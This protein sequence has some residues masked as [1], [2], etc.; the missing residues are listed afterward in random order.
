M[1]YMYMCIA[2]LSQILKYFKGTN[3]TLTF[4]SFLKALKWC[5]MQ[6]VQVKA[7]GK[8]CSQNKSHSFEIKIYVTVLIF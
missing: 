8:K 6:D 3:G 2:D 7:R 1:V 5:E 4:E